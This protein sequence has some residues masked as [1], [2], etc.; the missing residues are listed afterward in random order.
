MPKKTSSAEIVVSM[1]VDVDGAPNAYGPDNSQALDF[2]LNA[3]VGAKKNGAI[4]GYLTKN[5]DGKTPV[6]QGAGDPFPGFFISTTGYADK[7]NARTTDPRRYVNAAEINYTLHAKAAKNAGVKMGDFCVVHSLRTRQTVFAIVGDSGNSSGAEGSL[8]LLQRLG[9]KVKNGKAGGED[10][11]NIVVR[12]FADTNPDRLF[13]FTQAELEAAAQK[14]DLDTDFS[15][16]HPG[17]PGHL[18]FDEVGHSAALPQT[19]RVLPFAPLG[20]NETAPPYPGH[21]IKL[22]TED[23]DSAELIQQRLRD[24]G[25]T[26]TARDGSREPLGADGIF[27]SDTESAVKLF[28]TRHTD[29]HGDPLVPDGEVGSDTWGALFGRDTV[30]IS[31]P[32]AE[33]EFLAKVLEVASGEV[34]VL[35]DPPGSNKGERVEQ[36]MATVGVEPGDPW[37]VAFVF[38]CFSTAAKAQG[39]PN[40][41]VTKKC[42]T[43]GVLDLWNR[44]RENGV[45]VVLQEDALGDPS[46]VKPGMIFIISTGNGHGHTGLVSRVMGNRLETIEGNTNDGGSREGIGVFRREGRSIANI[47]RGFIDMTA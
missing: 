10:D 13:F 44:A 6:V 19:P 9:Y 43:G 12:Y 23:T 33:N 27:G 16:H 18:V 46:K 5:D 47:N 11:K 34:G 21:L 36:Y 37:C 38:F 1:A 31:P 25:F 26:Q 15:S 22:D 42:K 40:P 35:E 17:E 39:I 32:E 28:Q 2:E 8:A 3:R 14:L 41:M 30:H 7:N 29:L 20:K 24:L 45:A 4:V